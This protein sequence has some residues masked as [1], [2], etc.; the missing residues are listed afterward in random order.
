MLQGE[1]T[2]PGRLVAPGHHRTRPTSTRQLPGISQLSQRQWAANGTWTLYTPGG[3]DQSI[4]DEATTNLTNHRT[5]LNA[6]M[7]R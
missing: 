1:E 4:C 2:S 5:A 6:T 3:F 7:L